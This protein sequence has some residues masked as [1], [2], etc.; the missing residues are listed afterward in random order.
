MKLS[1][2]SYQSWGSKQLGPQ[3]ELGKLN[4]TSRSNYS[5]KP[6]FRALNATCLMQISFY[7]KFAAFDFYSFFFITLQIPFFII[8]PTSVLFK[9]IDKVC[10]KIV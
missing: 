4:F 8:M 3:D 2:A 5:I 6:V 9:Q 10:I 7:V 1:C